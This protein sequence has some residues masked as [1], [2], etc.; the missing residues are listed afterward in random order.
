MGLDL[1]L[2]HLEGAAQ[3]AAEEVRVPELV[4][5]AAVVGQ[6]DEVGQGVL[7]EHQ[8]ELLAVARPV[9]HGRCDVEEDLEADLFCRRDDKEVSTFGFALSPPPPPSFLYN[10]LSPSSGSTRND[11][12]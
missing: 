4:L 6:L 3:H 9:R 11:E 8:R 7:L 1:H 10:S 2:D 5:G 12:P